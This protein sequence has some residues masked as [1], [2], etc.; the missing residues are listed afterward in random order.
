MSGNKNHS[1]AIYSSILETVGNTPIVKI[2]RLAPEHVEICAKIEA[3]NPSGSLKDRM[4]HAILLDARR[5]GL[6]QASQ[7]V[8]EATSGNTGIALA[9]VCATMGHPFVAFMGD[10]NT[11]ERTKLIRSFGGRV[12]LVPAAAGATARVQAAEEYAARTGAFLARQYQ[13]P[14]NPGCHRDTT[15]REIVEAFAGRALDWFVSGWGTG[16]TLTGVAEM[17]KKERPDTKIVAAEPASAPMLQ[18]GSWSPH[19][20]LGWAPNFLPS[21]LNRALLDQVISV[22]DDEARHW[23]GALAK[24]EGILCGISSGGAFAAALAIARTRAAVG[25]VI[26]TI[27]PDTGERYLST[28]PFDDGDEP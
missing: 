5:R 11:I 16:G 13:N 28:M 15:G 4:A 27:F 17:L 23:A 22:S 19:E 6:L 3:F 9:M 26:L 8:A 18:S 2:Q 21:T 1:R 12:V 24:S 20:I 10:N 14:V 7:T 25:D